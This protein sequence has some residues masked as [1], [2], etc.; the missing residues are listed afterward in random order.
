MRF[1]HHILHYTDAI[2]GAISSQITSL[3]NRLFRCRSKK[4]SKLHVTGLCE[5]NAP[6]IGEFPAQMASNPKNVS[7][8]WRHHGKSLHLPGERFWQ[9][10]LP[11]V[12]I[13][14]CIVARRSHS[15]VYLIIIM[16]TWS[17]VHINIYQAY[18]VKFV[19][20][21]VSILSVIFH[22]IHGSVCFQLTHFSFGGCGNICIS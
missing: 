6:G 1:Y 16:Q 17:I 5:G 14:W 4:T 13:S 7:I 19:S 12:Q 11:Y 3:T 18:S 20:K 22:A 15:F 10:S 2:M 8:W 21:I 9:R